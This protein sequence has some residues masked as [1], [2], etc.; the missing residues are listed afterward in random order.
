[1]KYDFQLNNQTFE[2]P[3]VKS[4]SRGEFIDS[5]TLRFSWRPGRKRETGLIS[6]CKI[7]GRGFSEALKFSMCYNILVKGCEIIGGKEG[8]V[9]IVRGGG[10]VFQNCRFISNGQIKQHIA[11]R[12]GARDIA[13]KDCVF[14]GDYRKWWNGA[15]VDLGNWTDYDDAPR[16]HAR[17]IV[18]SNCKMEDITNRNL[19]RVL[20]SEKPKVYDCDGRVLGIP[21]FLV[22]LFWALKRK[23]WIGRRRRFSPRRLK[24]YDFEIT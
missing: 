24:V 1:M 16:P 4:F 6:G 18:V 15:C 19:C 12:G 23:G 22:K 13:I 10:V 20:Y 8:C 5:S 17:N 11:I 3:L 21:R 2:N 9:D 7:D 14:V